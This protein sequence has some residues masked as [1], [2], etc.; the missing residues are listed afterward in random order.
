MMKNA[1]SDTLDD[2][3]K[4]RRSPR[5]EAYWQNT[6]RCLL[7]GRHSHA[8][9]GYRTLIQQFPGVSQLWAELGLAAAG[10]LDFTLANQASQ[11]AAELAGTD[12]SLLVSIGQQYHR[13]RRPEQAG[14]CFERAVAADPSSVQARLGLA[15]WFDRASRLDEAW[16]C[17][18]ACVAQH[19]KDGRVLYFRA[20]L[21]HRKG[22]NSEAETAL[23]DLLK[24]G[25]PDPDVKYSAS[26]LLGVV[27]D[28]LGQYA[29]AMRWLDKAK[30]HLRQMTDTTALEQAYDQM[31]RA[32]R[33]LLAA[34]T[35]ET[36]R[37][38]REEAA[39]APGPPLL[40]LVGGAPRSG[41][42]LIGQ[43]L[44][45]RP[46]VLVFDESEAFAQEL[47]NALHPAPPAVGLTF[48][49]LN[50]LT[51]AARVRLIDRYCPAASC[52]WTKTPPQR[53]GFISGSVFFPNRK[54][55]SPCAIRGTSSLVAIFKT[56]P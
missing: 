16:E 21:L 38:W 41:T 46:D 9:A 7:E 50:A 44:G 11:R 6:Q 22:L 30:A 24:S 43:I 1:K 14:A 23:H 55:S 12:A 32:R 34:L 39:E 49:S 52:Y 33:K 45:T 25:S 5:A 28:A 18:E 40:T 48:K 10:D 2:L 42:A 35:P 8:L 4:L 53:R 27:L 56:S 19:P 51:T 3:A 29:E 17:V 15:A 13:L 37:R 36:V 54:S 20:F 31:D 47:L 26:H